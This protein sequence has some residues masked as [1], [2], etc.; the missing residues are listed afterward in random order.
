MPYIRFAKKEPGGI[1]AFLRGIIRRYVESVLLEPY[2]NSYEYSPADR[3][4]NVNAWTL[5][6]V[7]ELKHGKR[8]DR[9]KPGI[10]QLK[11]EMDSLCS[12]LKLGRLYFEATEDPSPFDGR[13]R[14]A[15]GLILDTFYAMQARGAAGCVGLVF[16]R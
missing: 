2:A 13:W 12:V 10:H 6:N 14:E 15:V 5:D 1:G 4:C 11:W 7:T 16:S 9:M 3:R 8:V